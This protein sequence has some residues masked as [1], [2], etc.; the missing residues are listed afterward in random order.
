[1]GLTFQVLFEEHR[2]AV[3]EEAVALFD[4]MT[5]GGA[6][7]VQPGESRHQHEQRRLGQVKIREEGVDYLKRIRGKDEDVRFAGTR[8]E[9][10]FSVS[11]A[12]FEDSDHCRPDCDGLPAR[13]DRAGDFRPEFVVFT[14]H[15]MSGNG[16]ARNRTKGPDSD[17]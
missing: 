12:G 3:T 14:V 15:V 11:G 10:T 16:L 13:L 8:E 5:V 9:F 4:R 17:M 7:L 1:M 2:V 6:H